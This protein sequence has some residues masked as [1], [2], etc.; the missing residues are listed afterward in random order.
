MFKDERTSKA[1]TAKTGFKRT[2]PY[3]LRICL[4]GFGGVQMFGFRRVLRREKNE[5]CI[6]TVL[7]FS[8]KNKKKRLVVS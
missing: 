2:A 8:S 6:P 7:I 3:L 5:S 4:K 1:I